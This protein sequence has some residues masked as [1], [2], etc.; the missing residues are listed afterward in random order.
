[1]KLRSLLLLGI[2]VVTLTIAGCGKKENAVPDQ[3]TVMME[4]VTDSDQPAQKNLVE[5]ETVG[6]HSTEADE[7]EKTIG[8]QS[9]TAYKTRI[10]NKTG[11]EISTVYIRVNNDDSEE[12]GN[13][14]IGQS[15]TLKDGEALTYYY[16]KENSEKL[17]D[18][19]VGYTAEGKNECFFRKLPLH[20]IEEITLCMDGS[21]TSGIPFAKYRKYGDKKVISTLN[22]VKQRLGMYYDESEDEEED[23]SESEKNSSEQNSQ[24]KP[25]EKPSESPEDK[26]EETVPE[27]TGPIRDAESCIGQPLSVLIEKCGEPNGSAYENEPESG[28]TGY[29]YYE[30]FTVS[31]TIDDEGNEIVAGVW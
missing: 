20:S 18:I 8:I 17:Y 31:T 6:Q 11:G 12:W 27:T 19:R 7:E 15:F 21:G 14:Q 30:N 5:M 28:S 13:E 16:E 2:A 22:E 3:Q 10:I 24:P 1:M 29:H 9:D 26:P 25:T 23:Y 4:E